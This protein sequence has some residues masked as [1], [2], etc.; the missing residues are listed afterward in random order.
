MCITCELLSHHRFGGQGEV[1]DFFCGHRLLDAQRFFV[2]SVIVQKKKSLH[3]VSLSFS[4]VGGAV[5]LFSAAGE[6]R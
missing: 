3:F 5:I 2:Y 1:E 4:H 6:N